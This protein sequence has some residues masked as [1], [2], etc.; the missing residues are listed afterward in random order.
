MVNVMWTIF[1]FRVAV[2]WIW[3]L[4]VLALAFLGWA[5][6][7]MPGNQAA[8]VRL[9]ASLPVPALPPLSVAGPVFSG[10]GGLSDSLQ[11]HFRL[12]GTFISSS[13]A[14]SDR[15]L[16]KAIIDLLDSDEQVL[17]EEGA[18]VGEYTVRTIAS[19]YVMLEGEEEGLLRLSLSF[20]F[21]ESP[22]APAVAAPGQPLRRF[23]D[24][25]ALSTSRFGKQ[26]ADNRWVLRRDDLMAYYDEIVHRPDRLA[27]LFLSM[28]DV[29]EED[30]LRGYQVDMKGEKDLFAAL[31]LQNGDVLRSVNS[32]KMTD[33]SRSEFMLQEFIQGRLS[34]VVFDIEREGQ[35]QKLIHLIR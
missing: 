16:R 32:V 21:S 10:P 3:A 7:G 19:K 28:D 34:A 8:S 27:R 20:D 35:P 17:V 13:E 29:V 4:P 9:M 1:Q 12:A 26:I 15:E 31:G 24:M 25:P 2:L 5:G 18:R 23:E 11:D 6:L 30:Q 22:S 33:P 14:G